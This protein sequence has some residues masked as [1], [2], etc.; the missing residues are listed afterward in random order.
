MLFGTQGRLIRFNK[1]EGRAL[2]KGRD[3]MVCSQE[4]PIVF[5]SVSV[6]VNLCITF[7]DMPSPKIVSSTLALTY[8]NKTRINPLVGSYNFILFWMEWGLAI[9]AGDTLDTRNTMP[10]IQV[11]LVQVKK[12]KESARLKSISETRKPHETSDSLP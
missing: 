2:G 5:Y 6:V 12:A 11:S 3:A 4:C 7:H 10:Q 8:L 9:R 1:Q